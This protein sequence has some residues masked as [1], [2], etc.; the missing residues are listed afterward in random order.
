MPGVAIQLLHLGRSEGSTIKDLVQVIGADPAIAARLTKL[1]N[2]AAYA[3]NV[4]AGDLLSAVRFIGYEN[5]R[6]TALAA[7]VVPALH[8]SGEPA[9]AHKEYWR[10][11]AIAAVCVRSVGRRWFPDDVES[12]FLSA[13]VQDI[14]VLA[15]TQTSTSLYSGLDESSYSHERAIA[16]ERKALHID[17]AEV[18]SWLLERWGFPDH[19]VRAVRV[20]NNLALWRAFCKEGDDQPNFAAGVMASGLLADLWMSREDTDLEVL[21]NSV[22]ELLPV[23][24]SEVVELLSDAMVEIPL[25]ES[26][27]QVQVPDLSQLQLTL[28]ILK[29]SLDSDD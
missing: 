18:G 13:L 14:G 17:H 24:W 10:R 3:R 20:S 6:A 12:L 16:H 5:A 15:L 1:A 23:S 19:I 26:L 22:L 4:P 28:A 29:D 8:R 9:F 27:C 21:R 11:S 2:S 25:V 7:T